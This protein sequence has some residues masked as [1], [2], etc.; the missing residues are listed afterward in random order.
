[1]VNKRAVMAFWRDTSISCICIIM[2]IKTKSY[3][4]A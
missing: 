2:Q 3:I 4:L 1:M